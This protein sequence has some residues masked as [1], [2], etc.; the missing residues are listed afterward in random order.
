MVSFCNTAKES[1]PG[2]V[3]C[4]ATVTLDKGMESSRLPTEPHTEQ[5]S[6][7]MLVAARGENT[8]HQGD[9]GSGAGLW[10]T[11]GVRQEPAE[12]QGCPQGCLGTSAPSALP[13]GGLQPAP[14]TK[15][16]PR[17]SPL[18]PSLLPSYN[19]SCACPGHLPVPSPELQPGMDRSLQPGAMVCPC[20]MS[21]SQVTL[22]AAEYNQT[23]S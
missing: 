8:G 21:P 1:L 12:G 11:W 4:A 15:Q 19:N 5:R 17:G 16:Q 22:Q 2:T 9:A 18:R 3:A 20:E 13:W 23:S 7:A 6:T 10:A 14:R